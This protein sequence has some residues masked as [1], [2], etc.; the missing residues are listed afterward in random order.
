VLRIALTVGPGGLEAR[1][2]KSRGGRPAT[3]RLGWLDTA[4][5]AAAH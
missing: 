4:A 5:Q 3:I 2:L 1:I